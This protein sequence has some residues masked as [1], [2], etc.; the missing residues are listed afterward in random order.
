MVKE[1]EIR[2]AHLIGE[3][4]APKRLWGIGGG[5]QRE[6]TMRNFEAQEVSL[7]AESKTTTAEMPDA[8]P[9]ERVMSRHSGVRREGMFEQGTRVSVKVDV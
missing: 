9:R 2:L 1:R 3:R 5:V 8:G 7:G 6:V 4:T